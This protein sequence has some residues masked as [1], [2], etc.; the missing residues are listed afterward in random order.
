MQILHCLPAVSVEFYDDLFLIWI[1]GTNI[2]LMWVCSIIEPLLAIDVCV[3]FWMHPVMSQQ[4][5]FLLISFPDYWVE[6]S[7]K[8]CLP[9][10]RWM[11]TS[12]VGVGN[13][14]MDR[15]CNLPLSPSTV[16]RRDGNLNQPASRPTDRLTD[17]LQNAWITKEPRRMLT[18]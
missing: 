6:N 7:A 2:V 14:G 3:S 1:L 8:Y 9:K 4:S 10:F 11:L 15:T 18:V 13:T 12:V 17:Q 5:E 16:T